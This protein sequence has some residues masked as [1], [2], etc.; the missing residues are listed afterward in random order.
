[1]SDNNENDIIEI[2]KNSREKIRISLS[3]FKGKKLIDMR[4]WYV[5]KEGEYKPSKK[6]LSISIDKYDELKN[7]ILKLENMIG[8]E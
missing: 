5:D 2:E 6:G 7:A 1:M 4:I 3:E 8:I